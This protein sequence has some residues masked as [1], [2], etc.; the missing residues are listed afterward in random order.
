M[1]GTCPLI[2][3]ATYWSYPKLAYKIITQ[4]WPKTYLRH[5]KI[6]FPNFYF[7]P[8]SEGWLKVAKYEV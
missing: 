8:R 4:F 1:L 7:C 6:S 3:D 2:P 5:S